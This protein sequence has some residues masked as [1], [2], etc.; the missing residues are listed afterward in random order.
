LA[1]D[2]STARLVLVAAAFDGEG[3]DPEL[4]ADPFFFVRVTI[5]GFLRLLPSYVEERIFAKPL[6]L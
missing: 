1:G 5:C 4:R 6:D 2:R 3:F